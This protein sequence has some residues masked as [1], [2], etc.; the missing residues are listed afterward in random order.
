MGCSGVCHSPTAFTPKRED[1][2]SEMAHP[3]VA[4]GTAVAFRLLLDQGVARRRG[5]APAPVRQRKQQAWLP[6]VFGMSL[7]IIQVFWTLFG[8]FRVRFLQLR[9]PDS[10]VCAALQAAGL[11]TQRRKF[12]KNKKFSKLKSDLTAK[13]SGEF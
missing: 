9:Q 8:I 13:I 1:T 11:K 3:R 2:R 12:G 5:E 6:L 4:D 10:P 7:Y